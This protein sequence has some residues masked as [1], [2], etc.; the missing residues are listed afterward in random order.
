M[1]M[2]TVVGHKIILGARSVDGIEVRLERLWWAPLPLAWMAAGM[3]RWWLRPAVFCW[4][5]AALTWR[6]GR[7]GSR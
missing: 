4:T 7:E 2:G 3:V 5:I 1:K 6:F